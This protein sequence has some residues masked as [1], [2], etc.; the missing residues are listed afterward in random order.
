[1][2]LERRHSSPSLARLF[3]PRLQPFRRNKRSLGSGRS[4]GAMVSSWPALRRM[5]SRWSW[6]PQA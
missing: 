1:M 3:P 4:S 2:T 5:R 6:R